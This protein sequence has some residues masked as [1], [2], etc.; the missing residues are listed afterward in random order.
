MSQS[1]F[2]RI[3]HLRCTIV[4]INATISGAELDIL[5]IFRAYAV[6]EQQMLFFPTNFTK[7]QSRTFT[8]AMQSM[9]E[10]GWVIK[11]RRQGAYSLTSLG[12]RESLKLSEAGATRH[13]R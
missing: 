9:I 13:A 7:P 10:R 6:K 5:K 8:A 11:E 3:R 4:S 2:S 1:H 12:Y